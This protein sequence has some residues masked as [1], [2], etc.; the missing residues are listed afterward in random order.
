MTAV[1]ESI[2]EMQ[3][4]QT[5]SAYSTSLMKRRLDD[6]ESWAISFIQDIGKFVFTLAQ[7]AFDVHAKVIPKPYR[8]YLHLLND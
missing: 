4:A 1:I 8:A 5:Q 6:A 2:M 3:T 7:Y